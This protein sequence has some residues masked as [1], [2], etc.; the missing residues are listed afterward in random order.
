MRRLLVVLITLTLLV[1]SSALQGQEKNFELVWT[2]GIGDAFHEPPAA[3]VTPAEMETER[4]PRVVSDHSVVHLNPCLEPFPCSP[5]TR[6][7]E[8]P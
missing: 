1:A 3:L 4:H 2:G 5:A 8:P 6:F 7:V